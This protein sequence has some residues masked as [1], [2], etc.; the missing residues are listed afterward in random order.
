MMFIA[1]RIVCGRIIHLLDKLII[2][3]NREKSKKNSREG[4]DMLPP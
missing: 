3:D 1:V 4:N 2:S